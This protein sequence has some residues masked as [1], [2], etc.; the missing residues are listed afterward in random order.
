MLGIVAVGVVRESRKFRAPIYRAHR[1]V[2]FA[3]AKL[4]CKTFSVYKSVRDCIYTTKTFKFTYRLL[5]YTYSMA[6]PNDFDII[7]PDKT[8]TNVISWHQ[9]DTQVVLDTRLVL[10]VLRYLV[11]TVTLQSLQC[12]ARLDILLTVDHG[13][14]DLLADVTSSPSLLAL[15]RRL[16]YIYVFHSSYPGL[17]F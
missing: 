5:S 14:F 3:T 13:D 4:S 10:E 6:Y 2:I 9:M 16:K 12:C 17:S 7:I 1:A 8:T 11:F 15:K